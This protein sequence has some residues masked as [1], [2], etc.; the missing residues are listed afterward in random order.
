MYSTV[1]TFNKPVRAITNGQM[2]AV[3]RDS[4]RDDFEL[5][6]AQYNASP[7]EGLKNDPTAMIALAGNDVVF[8]SSSQKGT[9]F[10]Y[11]SDDSFVKEYLEKCRKQFQDETGQDKTHMYDASCGEVMVVQQFLRSGGTV[12][13][14]Q[15]KKA[16]WRIVAVKPQS[17][18]GDYAERSYAVVDP[19]GT[20]VSLASMT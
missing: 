12:K 2:A 11:S 7:K 3:A 5:A 10:A 17:S 1:V 13:Q 15:D 19:C 9:N 6:K 4:F 8:L 18:K 20:K 14:L 16:G